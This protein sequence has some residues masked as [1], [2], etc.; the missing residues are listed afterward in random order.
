[1][2]QADVRGC[3]P[4]RTS[5]TKR[6][7]MKQ[8]VWIFLGWLALDSYFVSADEVQDKAL[9]SAAQKGNVEEIK[10]QLKAG[11]KIDAI[12]SNKD[13]YEG[14]QV[15]HYAARSG[16]IQ[17]VKFL[18]AA[19]AKVD[20][21]D[22]HGR[23]PLHYAALNGSVD[24]VKALLIAGA[25]VNAVDE[26]EEAAIHLAAEQ[27]KIEVVKLLIAS[28]AGL[29]IADINGMSPL[30]RAALAGRAEGV[31]VLLVAGAKANPTDRYGNHLTQ[32][33][34]KYGHPEIA[35]ILREFVASPKPIA[36]VQPTK[37]LT[38]IS[39]AKTGRNM[40]APGIELPKKVA[41]Y[42]IQTTGD[43]K[44]GNPFDG[45]I[46]VSKISPNIY[47]V[48][49]SFQ[50]PIDMDSSAAMIPT[51]NE[52]LAN[53]IADITH[54][55]GWDVGQESDM[56]D[57]NFGKPFSN[58]T[59][60]ILTGAKEGES[61]EHATGRKTM[62][63]KYGDILDNK[64]LRY[65]NGGGDC[66]K[67]LKPEFTKHTP[68]DIAIEPIRETNGGFAGG[69][70]NL[71]KP[72]LLSSGEVTAGYE[73]RI[74]VKPI[75]SNFYSV[76]Y[77]YPE[78]MDTSTEGGSMYYSLVQS[79]LTMCVGGYLAGKQGYN[80]WDVGMGQFLN[81]VG[82]KDGLSSFDYYI[83]I[84]PKEGVSRV[85]ATR[86]KDIHWLGEGSSYEILKSEN[87]NNLDICR[88]LLKPEYVPK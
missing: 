40:I 70:F 7:S 56:Y 64:S 45:E 9:I 82:N 73:A 75:S 53:H 14:L 15:I 51:L 74:S 2:P 57:R 77:S 49:Y 37:P 41:D 17:E 33:T 32:M 25:Q 67:L 4:V 68:A 36:P 35:K 83:L 46:T 69:I 50:Q 78:L 87:K 54:S 1:M 34:E 48:D 60:L 29:E 23:Q 18:L 66:K 27:N 12:D 10:R 71:V 43:W 16:N 65:E 59:Y 84:N 5:S 63:W 42:F 76:T 8:I 86:R 55:P 85:E 61:R 21:I 31:K 52:C 44:K 88:K 58:L 28:G 6:G 30:Y 3:P 80:V 47:K 20:A 13:D 38:A 26:Y 62:S 81:N 24:L 79:S 72:E 11:A 22:F 39:P 19:G